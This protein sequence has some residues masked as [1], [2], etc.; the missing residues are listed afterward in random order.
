ADLTGANANVMY[1]LGLRHT[2]DKLTVQLGEFGR[3]PF[4]VN[5]IRTIQFSRSPVGLINARDELIAV[6]EAGLAGDY[7]PVSATRVWMHEAESNQGARDPVALQGE[8]DNQQAD[9]EPDE[10]GFI[11]VMAEAEEKQT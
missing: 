8:V 1:E 3:L 4:D 11:D 5:V 9:D 10:R 2:R 7:D 6:L